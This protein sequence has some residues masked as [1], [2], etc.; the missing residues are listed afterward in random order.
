MRRKTQKTD[1]YKKDMQKMKGG[2]NAKKDEASEIEKTA[3]T[4]ILSLSHFSSER[5]RILFDGAF[6]RN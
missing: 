1:R 4:N 5:Q 3:C 6:D 2:K